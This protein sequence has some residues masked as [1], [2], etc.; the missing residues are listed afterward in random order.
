LNNSEL[1]IIGKSGITSGKSIEK[2][3]WIKASAET[4]YRSLTNSKDLAKW[5]CDEAHCNPTMGGELKAHWKSGKEGQTGR[6][7]I[8]NIMPNGLLELL[9]VEEGRETGSGSL[10]HTLSFTIKSKSGMT[11]VIMCDRDEVELDEETYAFLDRGWNS[12][13]LELK[14]FCERKER[15][16]KLR[17]ESRSYQDGDRSQK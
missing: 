17:S 4:V 16:G 3:V 10:Q 6:A 1:D 9:W 8:T 13:L 15:L 7:V 2:R 11:E 5:F 12:V 14:D